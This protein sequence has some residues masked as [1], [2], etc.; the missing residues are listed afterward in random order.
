[1]VN[2]NFLVVWDPGHGINTPGKH[3][4]DKSLYEYQ[5]NR[6]MANK[7]DVLFKHEG[8]RSQIIV[9]EITDTK[10]RVRADRVNK[11]CDQ[12]GKDNI[13]LISVHVNAHKDGSVWTPAHGI[14][15]YVYRKEVK[16]KYGN[17]LRVEEASSRSKKM[18]TLFGESCVN[19]GLHLRV[20][21]P[22]HNYWME[23]FGILR[24]TKCPAILTENFFMT[25]QTDL[26]FIKSEEGK[27]IIAKTHLE[28][29]K[30][31]LAY[32]Y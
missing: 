2:D 14:S 13:L 10:I 25:N 31:Y 20:P 21:D 8:I 7:M 12:Y 22:Y 16:D 11:L 24:L 19:N 28:A 27:E 9:P 5:W 3:S 15:S 30:S 18:A 6:E 4:T 32:Y 26:A 23:N 1:M 29:V 17:V